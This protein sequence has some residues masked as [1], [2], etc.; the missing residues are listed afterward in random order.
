MAASL[1]SGI[2][3][4]F[5][6]K[7]KMMFEREDKFLTFP[8]GLGFTYRYLQ[9]MQDPA[10]SGLS[11]QEQ[12]NNKGDFA[13]LMNIIPEDSPVFSPDA[14][15]LLWNRVQDLLK[16]SV[17]ANSA[18][19]EGEDKKLSEAIDFLTDE[20]VTEGEMRIPT[21]SPALKRYYEYKTLY[22]KA[23]STYLD[24]KITVEATTGA[25]G[26]VLK[27]QWE[28]YREKQL[29]SLIDTAEQ[30]WLNLGLKQQ[31]EGYLSVRSSL[32][33]KKYLNLYRQ[34]YLDDMELSFLPPLNDQ[35]LPVYTTFFSPFDAFDPKIPWTK[36]TLTKGEVDTLIQSSPAELK[37]LFNGKPL[38]SEIESISL[39]YNNVVIMRAWWRPEF[40]ESRY[41]KLPDDIL[42]SDGKLP[43]RG[44]IP[45][46]ITSASTEL[47]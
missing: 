1:K 5:A 30:D 33:P 32:E 11:L 21:Y 3:L 29:K 2:A 35:G 18:L 12:L 46:Y 7:L 28:S 25:E 38:E 41:W 19:T 27:Q 43:R 8:V 34:S 42:V 31:I 17:F 39:E 10:I 24:E 45:A 36:V 20:G 22:E 40:C 13:K 26:G 4:A 9:F 23:M 15:S 44:I 47:S 16:R 37:S 14:S 6:V